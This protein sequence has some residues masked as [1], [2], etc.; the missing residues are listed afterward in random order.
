MSLPTLTHLATH[1]NQTTHNY[2]APHTTVAGLDPTSP[3]NIHRSY[4]LDINPAYI[5]RDRGNRE[6][7]IDARWIDTRNGLFIDITAVSETMPKTMSG[8]WSC[9][10]FHHYELEDLWPMR[11]TL[12]EGVPA[13]VPYNYV[14][15]LSEEY[16]EG[17]LVVQNYEGYVL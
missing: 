4:L 12:F 9:K 2:T 15:I 10:N 8:I 17:A 6:N 1:F 13:K 5:D 16:K 3:V 7:V 14:K 11:E